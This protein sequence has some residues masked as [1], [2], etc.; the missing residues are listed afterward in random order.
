MAVGVRGR[1]AL[2]DGCEQKILVRFLRE[3]PITNYIELIFSHH[4]T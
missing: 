1:S 2:E 4:I 3:Y